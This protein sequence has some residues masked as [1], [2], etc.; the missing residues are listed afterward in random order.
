MRYIDLLHKAHKDELKIRRARRRPPEALERLVREL[1]S[2]ISS[3]IPILVEGYRDVEAL[4]RGFGP[5][6]YIRIY[7]KN[8]T[9]RAVVQ[10]SIERFGRRQIIMTDLDK[11]GNLL[12]EKIMRIINDIGGVG[13]LRYRTIMRLMNTQFVEAID[14]E[15]IK[16][17]LW[18]IDIDISPRPEI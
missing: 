15:E 11:K 16:R 12:A 6:N 17:I 4:F 10:D 5:G 3:G 18:D 1:S 9:L 8:I 7:R 2:E 14:Y 13:I